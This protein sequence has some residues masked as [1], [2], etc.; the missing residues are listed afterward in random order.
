MSPGQLRLQRETVSTTN[1][2]I[3]GLSGS[4]QVEAG[5]TDVWERV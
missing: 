2:T 5:H 3:T 4:T 1:R